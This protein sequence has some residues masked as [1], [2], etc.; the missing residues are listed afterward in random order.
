MSARGG[1]WPSTLVKCV[2]SNKAGVTVTAPGVPVSNSSRERVPANLSSQ[3]NP[4]LYYEASLTHSSFYF[5]SF[6]KEMVSS[7]ISI[8]KFT[9]ISTAR[10]N[11]LKTN[12]FKMIAYFRS[13]SSIL[14]VKKRYS[15]PWTSSNLLCLKVLWKLIISMKSIY[16]WPWK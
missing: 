11:N 15:E 2:Y 13:S 12:V 7:T 9:A 6:A 8:Q 10:A 5:W 16:T 1:F 14:Q 3:I 4:S